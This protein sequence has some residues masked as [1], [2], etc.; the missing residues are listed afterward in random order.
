MTDDNGAE[1][2]DLASGKAEYHKLS[3]L[4]EKPRR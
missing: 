2:F 1:I 4:P 3:F